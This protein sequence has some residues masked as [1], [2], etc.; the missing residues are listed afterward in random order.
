MVPG[1]S[2]F[3]LLILSKCQD[4]SEI[5]LNLIA[6]VPL[7]RA[8]Q[9][10]LSLESSHRWQEMKGRQSEREDP[11]SVCKT[12]ARPSFLPGIHSFP[13]WSEFCHHHPKVPSGQ[14]GLTHVMS[15]TS[16]PKQE[17][18][19]GWRML[20]PLP[21]PP[22]QDSCSFLDRSV[23]VGGGSGVGGW[24]PPFP[25][26]CQKP[27]LGEGR[28]RRLHSLLFSPTPGAVPQSIAV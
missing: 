22:C 19:C 9:R 1:F 6:H 25:K 12:Q 3:Y 26:A 10:A 21:L 28:I 15:V 4:P 23:V 17:K 14:G 20:G 5:S 24:G 11:E 2:S 18:T 27:I 16:G 7:E 8:S 13:L